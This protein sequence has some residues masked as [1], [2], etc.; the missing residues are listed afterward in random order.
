MHGYRERLTAPAS[1]WALALLFALAVGWAFFVATPPWV[2]GV[3]AAV[4][5]VVALGG[6][7]VYGSAR[8]EVSSDGF[9]AGRALLPLAAVGRVQPLDADASHR[10]AG[11][12]ADARAYMVLRGYCKGAVTVEVDDPEDPTPYWL[13][14][15]RRPR[16]LASALT[17][18]SMQD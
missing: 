18:N 8:V 6:V 9:R 10:A 4:A 16:E 13:V 17:S 15:T 1:W 2:A 12:D 11:A 7:A 14:S 5:G 3:A